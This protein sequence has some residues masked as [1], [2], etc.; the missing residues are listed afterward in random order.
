[1]ST[2]EK[3]RQAEAQFKQQLGQQAPAAMIGPKGVVFGTTIQISFP[4]K[5][6]IGQQDQLGQ[7]LVPDNVLLEMVKE[8]DAEV[9]ARG[10][11]P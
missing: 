7:K 6:I 1:M 5:G 9:K 11:K 10:L 8:L 2:A 3:L 4:F